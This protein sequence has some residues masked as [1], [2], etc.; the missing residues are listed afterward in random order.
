M[1]IYK[2]NYKKDFKCI[3][4]ALDVTF[5]RMI[6]KKGTLDYKK[7]IFFLKY[8]NKTKLD[9]YNLQKINKN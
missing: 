5:Y 1:K 3:N 9:S 2:K 7:I 4:F 8:T 6:T